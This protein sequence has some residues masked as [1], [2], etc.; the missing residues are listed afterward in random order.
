MATADRK[1]ARLIA[2]SDIEYAEFAAQQVAEY[3]WQL[4]Q[5]GEVPSHEG[6]STAQER[7]A[8]L[9]AD[10]LRSAGHD[11]LVA[12]SAPG[13]VRVG[14]VWLSPA[15]DPS[16]AGRIRWL[17]QLT[18]LTPHRG[19]GWGHAILR[20]LE[21]HEL[22]RGSEEIWLRVFDWN[23]AAKHLYISHGYEL[24][25]QFM[26]DAHLRKHLLVPDRS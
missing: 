9:A 22:D 14:W 19:Q 5:A 23:V 20:E 16:R 15:P 17:S 25:Q 2:C 18:V 12:I 3:A 21:Q 1:V 24:V 6:L 8:D 7:L 4:V 26:T 11:F 13:A 10:R